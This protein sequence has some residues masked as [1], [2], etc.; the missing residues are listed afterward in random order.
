MFI[1]DLDLL[2]ARL[3]AGSGAPLRDFFDSIPVSK[4]IEPSRRRLEAV[5]IAILEKTLLSNQK[6]KKEDHK[7]RVLFFKMGCLFV[8]LSCDLIEG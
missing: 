1:M 2:L 3:E 6:F 7:R 4:S 8:W 5:G